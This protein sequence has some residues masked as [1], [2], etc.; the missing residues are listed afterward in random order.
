MQPT[1]D[2]TEPLNET[3]KR[4]LLDRIAG[5]RQRVARAQVSCGTVWIKRCGRP[6]PARHLQA[7]AA[8]LVPAAPFLR[9]SPAV[10][11]R[12]AVDRE[13]R[14]IEAF[15]AAGFLAPRVVLAS[16][17]VVVL[18]DLGDTVYARMKALRDSDPAA[19]D[20]LLVACARTLGEVHAAGL[21]HGRPH[22]RDFAVR[23]G[24]IGFFDFEEEPAAVMPLASAQA[25]DIWLLFFQIAAHARQPSTCREALDIWLVSASQDAAREL[26][27]IVGFF[28]K[29]LPLA[30]AICKVYLGG[31]LDRFIKATGFL[32]DALFASRPAAPATQSLAGDARMTTCRR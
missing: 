30:R 31:D 32:A 3:D 10:R 9:P 25:R 8:R 17:P 5:G 15:R 2:E 24:R 19:H 28:A 13:I 16:G 26:M 12:R 4:L 21:C 29:L 23:D 22:P 6:H 14:Q 20:A 27:R 18:T 11:G 7:L 1:E